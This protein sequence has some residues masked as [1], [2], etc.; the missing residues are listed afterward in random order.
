MYYRTFEAERA[1]LKARIAEL[2]KQAVE[3]NKI[4]DARVKK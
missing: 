1:E 3:E 2:L 4:C